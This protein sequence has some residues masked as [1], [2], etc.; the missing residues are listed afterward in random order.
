MKVDSK[1][2]LTKLKLQDERLNIEMSLTKLHTHMPYKE[3]SGR[4]ANQMN[5][6]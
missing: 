4:G 3:I 2:H 1:F 6:E 5:A